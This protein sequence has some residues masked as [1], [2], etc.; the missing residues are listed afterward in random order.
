MVHLKA[1]SLYSTGGTGAIISQK[2][3]YLDR[4]F[5]LDFFEHKSV[6]LSLVQICRYKT[7]KSI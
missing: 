4:N 3:Q 2:S 5:H 7:N 1:V 6:T